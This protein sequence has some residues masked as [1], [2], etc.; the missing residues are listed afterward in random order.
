[1]SLPRFF[2]EQ[3]IDDSDD[4]VVFPFDEDA[5][6]HLVVRRVRP[7]E[8]IAVVDVDHRCH[9]VRITAIADGVVSGVATE[10]SRSSDLP[11][12]TLFQGIS[13]GERMD[14]TVRATTELGIERIVPVITQRV[15]VRFSSEDDRR[16]KVDRW[17]RIALESAKQAGRTQVPEVS[18][19]ETLDEAIGELPNFDRIIVAWEEQESGSLRDAL[20]TDALE[21]TDS[22][23]ALFIGPEGGL[24][25]EEVDALLV[26]GARIITLGDTILRTETAAIVA[27]ALVIYELGGLGNRK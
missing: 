27:S 5:Y 22:S 8:H 3:T 2:I 12:V 26:A 23:V 19:I 16:H 1:M 11:R 18:D 17:S 9:D 7:G 14:L 10:M 25:S 15:I 13:K 21:S 24:T 6:H 4:V 20:Y